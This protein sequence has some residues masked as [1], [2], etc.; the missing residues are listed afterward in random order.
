MTTTKQYRVLVVDDEPNI[1]RLFRRALER[2]GY[3][4][5]TAQSGEMAKKLVEIQGMPHI[6][7]IDLH[8]PNMGGIELARH[9][10]LKTD[11]PI[12]I[13]TADDH[14]DNIVHAL[15]NV[16]DDYI[17]KPVIPDVLIAHIE[18]VLRRLG[19]FSYAGPAIQVDQYLQ[20]D[21]ASQIILKDGREVTLTSTESK[22]LFILMRDPNT[23]ITP[24]I[25][26]N[27]IWDGNTR[28]NLLAVYIRHL[29]KKIE[30]DPANPRY[31]ISDRR[32]SS[33]M[34]RMKSESS[35]NSRF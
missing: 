23:W 20:V 24:T 35:D 18:A 12:I 2:Q 22:L 8:M 10:R 27:R 1:I 33:Y 7:L 15:K 4:V 16:A 13:V 21:F 9:F 31:I 14:P 3:E 29:R 5:L 30:E 17:T 25:L 34:F 28:S 11:L 32:T 6:A 19:D 26:R